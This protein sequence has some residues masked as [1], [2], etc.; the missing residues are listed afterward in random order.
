MSWNDVKIEIDS[1]NSCTISGLSGVFEIL[2]IPELPLGL[3]PIVTR[4]DAEK[5]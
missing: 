3:V 4:K 5:I 2:D 1:I